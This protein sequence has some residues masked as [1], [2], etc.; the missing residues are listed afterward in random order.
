MGWDKFQRM[1]LKERSIVEMTTAAYTAKLFDVKAEDKQLPSIVSTTRKLPV[2]DKQI[3]LKSGAYERWL[4]TNV[5]AQRSQRV[6][7]SIY[8]IRGW[9]YYR[10][11]T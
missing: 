8:N 11:P 9:R 4:H 2:I 3:D 5:V 10:K 1:I 7:Y 6:S